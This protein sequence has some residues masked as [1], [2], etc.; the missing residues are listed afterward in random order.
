MGFTRLI[1]RHKS[2]ILLCF[3]VYL[4]LWLNLRPSCPPTL[5][6]V[7]FVSET[8]SSMNTSSSFFFFSVQISVEFHFRISSRVSFAFENR[9][10]PHRS[11]CPRS[12]RHP[13]RL[14]R[15]SQSTLDNVWHRRSVGRCP[16]QPSSTNEFLRENLE[17]SSTFARSSVHRV[18][19]ED[20][21][22]RRPSQIS[23]LLSRRAEHAFLTG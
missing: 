19:R 16:S 15:Q 7:T 23:F 5:P 2:F 18:S 6:G 20:S 14:V 9:F 10:A 4:L 22:F 12:A 3:C 13:S 17:E 11:R 1:L 21:S 8:S